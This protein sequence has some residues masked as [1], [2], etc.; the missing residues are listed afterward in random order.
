MLA[1][2]WLTTKLRRPTLVRWREGAWIYRCRG[3]TLPHPSIGAAVHPDEARDVLL[4]GYT[5]QPGDVVLDVGAGIG[6]TTLLFS[7]LVGPTGRV[8]VR[9]RRPDDV[10][11]ELGL[12][13]IDLV[14]MNIEGAERV[15]L[16]GLEETLPRIRHLCI[17]CHDF[18]ADRG[19]PDE[20]RTQA[21]VVE[22]LA[23]HGF[24]LTTRDEGADW[25]QSYVYGTRRP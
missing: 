1:S 2:L 5:P 20:L 16:R 10:V 4:Y 25:V 12:E 23:A 22:F 17:S 11:R 19:G 13:G 21:F 3:A 15:A 9:A 8:V 18:V 7:E 6:D 14:K 24:E